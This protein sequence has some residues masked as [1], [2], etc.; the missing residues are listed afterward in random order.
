MASNPS[1]LCIDNDSPELS[2]FPSVNL[3]PSPNVTGG[4]Q[5]LY[6]GSGAALA[7]GQVGV[8]T[9]Y[10]YTNLN[11]ASFMVQWNGVYYPA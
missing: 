9:S 1:Y 7:P 10:H 5:L 2:Y 3:E 6:S 8:G 11:G 4:W